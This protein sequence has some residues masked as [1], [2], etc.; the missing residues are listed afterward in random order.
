MRVFSIFILLVFLVLISFG[1][2]KKD[3]AVSI[4]TGYLNSPY[5]NNAHS[6]GFYGAG[7]DYHL[8]GRQV[9]SANYLAGAH[10]YFDNT[11]SNTPASVFIINPKRTNAKATYNTFSVSYKYKIINTTRLSVAPGLG[12]GIMT[13]SNEYPYTQGTSMIFQTSSWSDL[14][15]PVTLDINFK[16]FRQWQLGLT[17]GFLIHPDFPILALHAGPKLSY[18]LK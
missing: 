3:L 1:Q 5:Y 6:R 17:S 10:D 2:E 9:L 15:F 12:A 8:S 14:V 13:H 7:F 4:S 11:L 18:I 16:A